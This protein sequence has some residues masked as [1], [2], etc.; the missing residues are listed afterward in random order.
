MCQNISGAGV[1]VRA[2]NRS[3]EKAQPLSD[4]GVAVVESAADAVSGATIVLT[5]L[6]DTDAVIA[7]IEP[8]VGEL[9]DDVIWLQMSTIGEAG[10]ERCADLAREHGLTLVDAPVL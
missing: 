7:S 8:V 4:D 3:S 10:H 2:W 1:E 5:M 9:G 6:S